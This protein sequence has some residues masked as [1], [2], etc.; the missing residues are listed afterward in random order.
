MLV[1]LVGLV[2]QAQAFQVSVRQVLVALVLASR[3]A[4]PWLE[5]VLRELAE[6]DIL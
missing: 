6:V 2:T 4:P 5:Q 1:G 3:A